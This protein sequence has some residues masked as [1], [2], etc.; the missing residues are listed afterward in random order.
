[1]IVPAILSSNFSQTQAMV[2]SC[3][4]FA[5]LIQIDIMDGK[6]VASKSIGQK[7]LSGLKVGFNSELHLMAENPFEWIEP[8]RKINSQ[9][10]IFHLETKIDHRRLISE[11]KKNG[12]EAGISL[13]PDTPVDDL[14]PLIKSIDLVLFMS[15]YPG[16]Y[17]ADFVP[18]VL[19][20]VKEFKKRWPGKKTAIDGGIKK[21]NFLKVKNAGLNQIC[22]GSA[23]L[24]A[25][26]PKKAFNQFST[27]DV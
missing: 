10:I 12:I 24:K 3:R 25:K 13:N 23:I 20:K 22:I 17:G 11:I 7:E 4:E 15:V 16:F 2:N 5:K 1:M 14:T 9:R 27:L 21:D 8:A 18:K 19:N 6:F 26:D